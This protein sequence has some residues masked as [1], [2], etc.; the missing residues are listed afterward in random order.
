VIAG[1]QYSPAGGG[2]AEE[3]G[4]PPAAWPQLALRLHHGSAVYS[5]A[6]SPDGKLLAAG[7]ADGSIH[8]WD[9]ATGKE[10]SAIHA[11]EQVVK[12]LAF[13]ADGKRLVSGGL[14]R[15]VRL[16]DLAA[17]TEL[18]KFGPCSGGI[19]RLALSPDC[20]RVAAAELLTAVHLWDLDTGRAIEN[21]RVPGS[22]SLLTFDPDGSILLAGGS[23]SDIHVLPGDRQPPRFAILEP[24]NTEDRIGTFWSAAFTPDGAQISGG[25]NDGRIFVW[26]ARTGKERRRSQGP[27]F[28]P[29]SMSC[30]PDGRMLALG[31]TDGIV[32]LWEIASAQER[33]QLVEHARDEWIYSVAFSPDGQLLASGS[34]DQQVLLWDLTGRRRPGRPYANEIEPSR[35]EAIWDDLGNTNAARSFQAMQLLLTA[36]QQSVPFLE[37]HLLGI[38]RI[39]PERVRQLIAELDNDRFQIRRQASRDLRSLGELVEPILRQAIRQKLSLEARHRIEELLAQLEEPVAS[40]DRLRVFRGVEVLEALRTP[41]AMSVLEKLAC[42]APAWPASEAQ[43]ALGRVARQASK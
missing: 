24:R 25:R 7:T 22:L 33:G 1:R 16:W 41:E 40:P 20:R 12:A 5:V 35:L 32:R 27:P 9:T 34:G 38:T 29:F 19:V 37:H 30:S 8:F 17:S 13:T 2:G 3:K 21:F 15:T 43:L 23:D 4:P 31:C 28:R 36:P 18:R 10:R 42:G 14:D 39:R 26:D 6:F 11:H